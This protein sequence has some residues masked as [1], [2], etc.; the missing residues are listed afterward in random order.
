MRR[1]PPDAG[2]GQHVG[3]QSEDRGENEDRQQKWADLQCG[4]IESPAADVAEQRRNAKHGQHAEE[5]AES[6]DRIA[7]GQAVCSPS[8]APSAS[9]PLRQMKSRALA[10]AWVAGGNRDAVDSE[11]AQGDNARSRKP[12]SSTVERTSRRLRLRC[13]SISRAAINDVAAATVSQEPWGANRPGE[14]CAAT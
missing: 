8:S 3:D 2:Q 14:A 9:G 4:F 12:M 11:S 13:V 5:E 7:A 10:R 6:S 1:T